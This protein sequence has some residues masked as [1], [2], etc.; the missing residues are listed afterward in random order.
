VGGVNDIYAIPCTQ[1]M[2]EANILDV[3]WWQ[4]LVDGSSPG[5]S[6]L[7][8]FGAIIGSIGKKTIKTERM[9]SC[10]PEG[11]TSV[12][13]ALKAIIKCFDRSVDRITHQQV[14]E[15]IT[16]AGN[17]LF[18][19][20]MCDGDDTIIPIGRATISDFDFIV[21]D[22]NEENQQVVVELSWKELALP[23]PYTVTGL[24]AVVPKA[25]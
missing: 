13:W 14:T 4:S 6:F 16:N 5:T 2:T 15:L 24:S 17:Y 12:T 25:A 23:K 20:R 19:A 18:I 3:A 7:G 10:V 11:V 9:S 21:P 8:N 1:E 22:N